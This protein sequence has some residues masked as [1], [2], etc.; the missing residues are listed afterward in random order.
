MEI[1]SDVEEWEV[2]DDNVSFSGNNDD[3]DTAYTDYAEESGE[4]EEEEESGEFSNENESLVHSS[5]TLNLPDLP[6][7]VGEDLLKEKRFE[8]IDQYLKAISVLSRF[9]ARN[10]LH[11]VLSIKNDAT[12]DDPEVI[13][14]VYDHVLIYFLNNSKNQLFTRVF[15]CKLES[16]DITRKTCLRSHL[17]WEICKLIVICDTLKDNDKS[18][19]VSDVIKKMVTLRPC[20]ILPSLKHPKYMSQREL[21]QAFFLLSSKWKTI[22]Y[23]KALSVYVNALLS[24]MSRFFCYTMTEDEMDDEEL[25]SRVPVEIL[26]SAE[27]VHDV[28]HPKQY[29]PN[30]DFLIMCQIRLYHFLGDIRYYESRIKRDLKMGLEEQMHIAI[31]NNK[32]RTFGGTLTRVD[33]ACRYDVRSWLS[34][35]LLKKFCVEGCKNI[36]PEQKE[37][38]ASRYVYCTFSEADRE[39]LLYK[40]P[41]SLPS[42]ADEFISKECKD[43]A[44]TIVVEKTRR[45]YATIF[46]EDSKDASMVGFYE[47]CVL[48]NMSRLFALGFDL[49]LKATVSREELKK[50]P[51]KSLY[52]FQHEK[53]LIVQFFSRYQVFYKGILYVHTGYEGENE[54]ELSREEKEKRSKNAIY[55]T[56]MLWICFMLND[57]PYS[58]KSKNI[59]TEL[60]GKY[61]E[62]DAKERKRNTNSTDQGRGGVSEHR[63]NVEDDFFYRTHK[64]LENVRDGFK[65]YVLG[66]NTNDDTTTGENEH[67]SVQS[68]LFFY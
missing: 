7:A 54:D 49:C 31:E 51:T 36:A 64:E 50:D 46:D 9:G 59:K 10:Y 37:K 61:A 4:I 28:V 2:L 22:D 58:S 30:L 42:F 18:N 21:N 68:S 65:R 63:T 43:A 8:I 32:R 48:K 29:A 24:R 25:R 26:P 67:A 47:W 38:T 41:V 62:F 60:E 45:T 19:N 16:E 20:G 44:Y 12:A 13:F 35:K 33:Q 52:V 23:T 34:V 1:E 27:A 3:Q 17:F 56:I 57:F 6:F 55:N 11:Y 40:K 39:W 53:P 66:Q 5:E 15:A 14:E